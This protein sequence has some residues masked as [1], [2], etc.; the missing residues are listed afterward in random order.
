MQYECLIPG[1][2]FFLF[3]DDPHFCFVI[4]FAVVF[5]LFSGLGFMFCFGWLMLL[6]KM[7]FMCCIFM[8][9][10]E[11]PLVSGTLSFE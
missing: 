5:V 4:V 8:F 11:K 2:H 3:G 9:L 6:R 10:G 1:D 7:S